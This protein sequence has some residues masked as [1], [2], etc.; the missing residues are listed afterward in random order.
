LGENVLAEGLMLRHW[1]NDPKQEKQGT[2]RGAAFWGNLVISP[3]N[4]PAR[5]IATD[6][7]TGICEEFFQTSKVD[8]NS[9]LAAPVLL[10]CRA[11]PRADVPRSLKGIVA[12]TTVQPG[13]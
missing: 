12:S 13:V 7:E 9:R 11:S 2:N 10:N 6:K 3:A 5:I 4:W 1:G 8:P